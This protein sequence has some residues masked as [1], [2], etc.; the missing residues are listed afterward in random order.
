MELKFLIIRSTV[1]YSNKN[2]IEHDIDLSITLRL[3]QFL[4]T[5]S[6]RH[7]ISLEINFLVVSNSSVHHLSLNQAQEAVD[8]GVNQQVFY[9][10]FWR[11]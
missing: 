10:K 5:L 4:R 9:K 6:L 2:L 11:I 7:D 3:T 8:E 1:V